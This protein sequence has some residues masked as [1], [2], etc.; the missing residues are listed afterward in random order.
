MLM[1]YLLPLVGLIQQPQIPLKMSIEVVI[2]TIPIITGS[3]LTVR[4]I[5]IQTPVISVDNNVLLV[6]LD[7]HVIGT[8]CLDIVSASGSVYLD[9]DGKPRYNESM[10]LAL[11][12]GLNKSVTMAFEVGVLEGEPFLRIFIST[13]SQSVNQ[14]HRILRREATRTEAI[15]L[16]SLTM[17]N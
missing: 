13:T 15:L 10:L 6:Q 4:K 16:A 7:N 9:D 12:A 3:L 17:L 2:C 11:R 5:R 8:C 1:I 14:I